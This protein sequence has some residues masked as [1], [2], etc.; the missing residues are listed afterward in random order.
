MTG[1]QRFLVGSGAVI[2]ISALIAI[3]YA[4][5]TGVTATPEDTKEFERLTRLYS[6]IEQNYYVEFDVK[7]AFTGA[8]NGMLNQLDPHSTFIDISD[9]ALMEERYRG[10]YQGIG[11]S[12]IMFD[13]KITVMEVMAGGPS[14]RVGVHMGDQIVEIEGESAIGL[15]SEEVQ[16]RLRGPDRTQ[17]SVK[18]QRP[19]HEELVPVTITR[20]QIPIASV[21]NSFML[22]Q[23][24]G[25]I[26]VTRFA[27]KTSRELEAE[28]ESLSKQGM[29]R[30][31]LDLRG[32]TGGF[33]ETSIQLVD[34]FIPGRRL[35]V[36]TD[37][38]AKGSR[39]RFFSY[40]GNK[41]WDLP[42]VVMVD[43]VSA[44]A[45]EIV[46]G[47]LQDWD[48]AVIAGQT[49]FGKG[50]VQT[51]FRLVDGSRLLLTTSR[52]YTPSG[53]LIQRDYKG[54][55]LETYQVQGYFD[56]DS[57]EFKVSEV[58]GERPVYLTAN[59]RTVFGGG[60]ITPDEIIDGELMFDPLVYSLNNSLI[61]FIYGRDYYWRHAGEWNDLGRF[62][63]DFEVNDEM[64][65]GLLTMSRERDYVY[66]P[67]QGEALSDAEM[68]QRFWELE[69][70]L[71]VF[72]K[73]EIAQ[74]YYDRNAGFTIRRLARDR[75]LSH[76]MD[77]FDEAVKLA[78]GQSE[79]SPETFANRAN[80]GG[81][82]E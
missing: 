39:E 51:G 15:D 59:G 17:V 77:L 47:A 48:R 19:H 35:I 32:N 9:Y 22:D 23:R 55:D 13:D 14:E 12:F 18:I 34:K 27:R 82:N 73:A 43:H 10:D 44:S 49:S 63:R 68:E 26:R 50:L 54:L 70:Q 2:L 69:D 65:A 7:N 20:G 58:E 42:L 79:I 41:Y 57:S 4:Q 80:P 36:Y 76:V 16:R 6:I 46:A 38:Q 75:Q 5:D 67:R 52:Y 8:L 62:M 56:Y 64:L 81:D 24:T 72:I 37:G 61:T 29:D 40:D 60:G 33:L 31:V 53:R 45:S 3:A 30:L 71:K 25:Y 21:E 28:M 1:T 78:V 11:V 74:F 66:Y